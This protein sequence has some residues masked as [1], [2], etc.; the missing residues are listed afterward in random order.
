MIEDYVR[1]Q[2]KVVDARAAVDKAADARAPAAPVAGDVE[3]MEEERQL[4]QA[5]A[6][7]LEEEKLREQRAKKLR[8][9]QQQG[10]I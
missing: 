3:A 7:S 1:E 5:L 2:D 6:V 10:K 8:E 4:Q 9:I